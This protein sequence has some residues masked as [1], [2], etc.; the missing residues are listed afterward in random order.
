MCAAVETPHGAWCDRLSGELGR[1]PRGPAGGASTAGGTG[2]F[3]RQPCG[4][5]HSISP[6]PRWILDAPSPAEPPGALRAVGQWR[7]ISLEASPARPGHHPAGKPARRAHPALEKPAGARLKNAGTGGGQR[8]L[9]ATRHARRFGVVPRSV[10]ASLREI[11][12]RDATRPIPRCPIPGRC[13]KAEAK[14]I[15]LRRG[16]PVPRRERRTPSRCSSRVDAPATAVR[17]PG[18]WCASRPPTSRA[19]PRG[20]A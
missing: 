16:V 2:G 19:S 10:G 7:W 1:D 13:A 14:P 17:G 18:V 8:G 6:F 4:G 12:C 5:T 15:A 20:S 9:R 3:R 11:R